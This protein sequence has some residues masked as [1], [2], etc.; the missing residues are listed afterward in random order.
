MKNEQCYM[1]YFF[2]KKK[3]NVL[4]SHESLSTLIVINASRQYCNTVC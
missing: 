3:K 4:T 2:F 1:E